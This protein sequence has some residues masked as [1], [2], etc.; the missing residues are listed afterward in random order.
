MLSVQLTYSVH[1][2]AQGGLA[3]SL[4]DVLQ[5]KCTEVVKSG[6]SAAAIV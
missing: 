2:H 1:G 6:S 4:N 5:R 3:P